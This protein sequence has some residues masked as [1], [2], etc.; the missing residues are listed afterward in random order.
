MTIGLHITLLCLLY[1]HITTTSPA[2]YSDALCRCLSSLTSG[3][4]PTLIMGNRHR[5]KREISKAQMEH[6]ERLFN[7]PLVNATSIDRY[8]DSDHTYNL[9]SAEMNF[10][11]EPTKE[12]HRRIFKRFH[13]WQRKTLNESMIRVQEELARY[14]ETHGLKCGEE[15]EVPGPDGVKIL[16]DGLRHYRDEMMLW[17]KHTFVHKPMTLVREEK[18]KLEVF[19]DNLTMSIPRYKIRDFWKYERSFGN[20]LRYYQQEIVD[21]IFA[22]YDQ[23]VLHFMDTKGMFRFPRTV[24]NLLD[25]LNAHAH[26]FTLNLRNETTTEF[27]PL[28]PDFTLDSEQRSAALKQDVQPDG[29]Y[30]T[31]ERGPEIF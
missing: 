19:T 1:I 3:D 10:F 9:S 23:L 31:I 4:D 13:R 12:F 6:I 7:D 29:G 25:H 5:P 22:H 26:L 2:P 16:Y 14:A 28:S 20:M 30:E 17:V 11:R 27:N 24:T 21:R 18:L 15:F 8:I